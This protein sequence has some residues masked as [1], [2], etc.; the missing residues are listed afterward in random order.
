MMITK[1]SQGKPVE[2]RAASPKGPKFTQ[3][4]IDKWNGLAKRIDKVESN[5]EKV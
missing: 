1:L 4:D 5:I 2:I 3:D